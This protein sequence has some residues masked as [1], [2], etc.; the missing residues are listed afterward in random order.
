MPN[1]YVREDAIE[2]EAVNGLS[3]QAEVFWRRL[4]NRV[5]DFGRY[6]AHRE[7]L[8]AAL[9]PLQ[10]DKVSSSD[11][12]K[13]LL[14]CEQAG[15]VRTWKTANGKE[16]LALTKWERGRA[17][18]SKYPD[19]P[20]DIQ[21][22]LESKEYLGTGVHMGSKVGGMRG[23]MGTTVPKVETAAL[24]SDSDSDSDSDTDS[25]QNT[26]S[27]PMEKR[28][29]F[30]P[31]TREELN[32]EAAKIGLPDSEVDRFVN[33]YGANGWKVG[34]NPMKSWPHALAGW[35]SRWRE[36]NGN[37]NHSGGAAGALSP[38]EK[39]NQFIIGADATRRQAELTAQRE[40][41][42]AERGDLPM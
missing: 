24:D 28:K 1:R 36:N 42:M 19:P 11:I 7:L 41:E 15:L 6:S 39:R 20:Q 32:L 25:D 26:N 14:E 34:K 13:L 30:V 37:R 5:D 12:G 22:A 3:W 35:A 8:R 9:F 16:F 18:K 4:L 40:R 17:D 21:A 31:P 29:K 33:Y 10:L 27:P 23:S 2:S 38:A